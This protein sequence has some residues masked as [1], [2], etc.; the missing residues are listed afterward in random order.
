MGYLKLTRVCKRPKNRPK[1]PENAQQSG[2]K[3]NFQFVIFGRQKVEKVGNLR[4]WFYTSPRIVRGG[5]V[6]DLHGTRMRVVK[7][8]C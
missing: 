5:S 8:L 2:G 1:W 3:K 7:G 6:V 4:K